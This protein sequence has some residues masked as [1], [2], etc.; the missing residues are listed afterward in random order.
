MIR[1]IIWDFDGTLFNTYPAIVYSFKTVLQSDFGVQY[2]PEEI[3][4]LVMVD[5][6][7]CALDVSQKHGPDP[8]AIL[9]KVRDFYNFQTDVAELPYDGSGEVCEFIAQRGGMNALVTHR[10][11]SSTIAML[12]RFRML[13]L[14]SLILTADDGFAPKPAPDSFCHVV[15][16]ASLDPSETLAVGDRDLDIEAAIAAGIRSAFFSPEGKVHPKADVSIQ[17]LREIKK[18]E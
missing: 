5:A 6:R 2:S 12:A 17:T 1:H 11:R 10:E 8:D 7:H 18:L 15:N 9:N 16:S 13:E 4:R 14:F 3:K